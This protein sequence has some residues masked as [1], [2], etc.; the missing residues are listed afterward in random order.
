ME[1][2]LEYLIDVYQFDSNT[3][4]F[5]IEV[6]L[7]EY[8]DIF[9]HLDPSP[10]RKRDLSPDLVEY[11]RL[12]SLEIPMNYKIRLSINISNENRDDQKEQETIKGIQYFALY[13][14][15]HL[16]AKILL[17]RKRSIKYVLFSFL[18]ITL[19]AFSPALNDQNI[20]M[21]FLR[22]GL[23]V[24]GWVFLWNAISLNF[25]DQDDSKELM[26]RYKRLSKSEIVFTYHP[27]NML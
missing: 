2:A 23:T 8:A 1:R 10:I 20:L 9:N 24:G 22:Q 5:N 27:V 6:I 16:N 21:N 7:P 18:F 17:P 13:M 11:I 15:N 26:K 19:S 4:T 25:I 14:L 12:C 3:N